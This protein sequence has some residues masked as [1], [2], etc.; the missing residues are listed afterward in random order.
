MALVES[1]PEAIQQVREGTQIVYGE[2][3][4]DQDALIPGEG[5][6]GEQVGATAGQTHGEL[7]RP[8]RVGL[9]GNSV[10]LSIVM[11]VNVLTLPVGACTGKLS[12]DVGGTS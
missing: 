1:L 5:Y 3:S 11:E 10:R 2:L 7:H 8:G 12:P 4:R 6:A 9:G